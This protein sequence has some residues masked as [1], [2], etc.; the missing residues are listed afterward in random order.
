MLLWNPLL[1]WY[2]VRILILIIKIDRSIQRLKCLPLHAWTL[3]PLRLLLKLFISWLIEGNLFF[4]IVILVIFINFDSL[5]QL[6]LEIL[7]GLLDSLLELKL[8]VQ[9]LLI[10][11]VVI[12]KQTLIIGY[13]WLGQLFLVL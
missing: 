8:F 2:L 4:T 1:L 6:R 7:S 10:S 11:E 9:H 12:D 5:V 13:V 3:R